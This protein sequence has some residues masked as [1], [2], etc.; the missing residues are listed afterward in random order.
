MLSTCARCCI[1]PILLTFCLSSFIR[2]FRAILS[3]LERWLFVSISAVRRLRVDCISRSPAQRPSPSLRNGRL[4][5]R[6]A[7]RSWAID[8]CAPTL[9]HA[10]NGQEE[11]YPKLLLIPSNPTSQSSCFLDRKSTRLNSSHRC[12]SYAVFCL[13]KKKIK[14]TRTTAGDRYDM[15]RCANVPQVR[16]VAGPVDDACAHE[17]RTPLVPMNRDTAA[18]PIDSIR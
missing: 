3:S 13:K 14:N 7:E 2:R 18:Y 17:A 16:G 9:Q 11:A 6:H 8:A 12:I 5:P 1:P 4:S 10:R 15:M